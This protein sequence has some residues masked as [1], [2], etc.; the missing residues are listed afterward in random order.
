[1]RTGRWLLGKGMVALDWTSLILMTITR[2][3]GA[4]CQ[5]V[6]KGMGCKKSAKLYF[7]TT[8]SHPFESMQCFIFSF[9]E[10]IGTVGLEM[11]SDIFILKSEGMFLK[12]SAQHLKVLH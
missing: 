5:R 4:T 8:S 1:M 7:P 10:T 3:S 2:L 11:A 6:V 12:S 9:M